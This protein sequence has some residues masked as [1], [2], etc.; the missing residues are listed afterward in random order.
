MTNEIIHC[1]Y[2]TELLGLGE[3]CLNCGLDHLEAI[4][5]DYLTGELAAR[6]WDGRMNDWSLEGLDA[7]PF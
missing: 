2:C 6:E 7:V 5:H 1:A 3:S 4:E